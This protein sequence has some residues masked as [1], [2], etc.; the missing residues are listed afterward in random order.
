[1]QSDTRK[2]CTWPRWLF[3]L[4]G[5]VWRQ[6]HVWKETRRETLGR[7]THFGRSPA[8][9]TTMYRIGVFEVCLL[10]GAERIR[11]VNSLHPEPLMPNNA[12][13]RADK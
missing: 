9:I 2:T 1:M 8:E 10:S 5:R 11:E 7:F 12:V 4:V 6:K 13:S 3:R